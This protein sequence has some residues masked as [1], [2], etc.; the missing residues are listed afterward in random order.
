MK[1]LLYLM[2]LIVSASTIQAQGIRLNGY[3]LYTF[4]DAVSSFQ[5]NTQYFDGKIKGGLTWGVGAEFLPRPTLGVEVSYYRMDTKAPVNFFN[6]GPKSATLDVALNWIMLGGNKYF[7]ANP[8]VE[9]YAGFMLGAG[10]V[11]VRNPDNGNSQG[12]TEFAWGLKGGV[13]IWASEKVGLKLQTNLMSMVQAVGGGLFFGTG[14]ASV[15]VSTFSTLLQFS[16]GGGL[17]I[18]LGDNGAS[19]AKT[20]R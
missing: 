17:V 16:L 6:N 18:K 8:K 4:D 1:K 14:G 7:G 20:T 19:P 13:N 12:S 15:G 9:P 3:A 2:F 10:I 5:S 11:D